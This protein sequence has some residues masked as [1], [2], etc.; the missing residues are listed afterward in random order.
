M[1]RILLTDDAYTALQFLN[2]KLSETFGFHLTHSQTLERIAHSAQKDKP[3]L[4]EPEK[5]KP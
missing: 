1:P 2:T 3:A 5:V 4:A